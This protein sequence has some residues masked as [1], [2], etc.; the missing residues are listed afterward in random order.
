MKVRR[1][2]KKNKLLIFVKQ[3]AARSRADALGEQYSHLCLIDSVGTFHATTLKTLQLSHSC[4]ALCWHTPKGK[5]RQ[6]SY[7]CFSSRYFSQLKYNI[8]FDM[9]KQIWV[10]LSQIYFLGTSKFQFIN[11]ICNIFSRIQGHSCNYKTCL[12]NWKIC[13]IKLWLFLNVQF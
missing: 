11:A 3:A 10:Y 4:L 2:W 9:L 6:L 7:G 13:C 5:L 12:R 1:L 8:I